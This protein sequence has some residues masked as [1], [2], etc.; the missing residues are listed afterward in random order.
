MKMSKFDL[1]CEFRLTKVTMAAVSHNGGLKQVFLRLL[2]YFRA[3]DVLRVA[4]LVLRSRLLADEQAVFSTI[5]HLG[6][7]YDV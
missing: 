7:K 5:R 2:E 3:L 4:L 1:I 6:P